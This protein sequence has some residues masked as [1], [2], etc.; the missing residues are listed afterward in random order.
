[1]SIVSRNNISLED[2]MGAQ[3]EIE[4]SVYGLVKDI[5]ELTN[6]S[7]I[8]R[9]FQWVLFEQNDQA[10]GQIRIRM[11]DDHEYIRTIKYKKNTD[12]ADG[13]NELNKP[14]DAEEFAY[15]I[16]IAQSGMYKD[17]YIFP[18]P[19]TE[20]KWE[21]DCFIQKD[22]SYAPW[23]K[24]DLEHKDPSDIP[25]DL[26]F[27]IGVSEV[28]KP[29]VDKERL[30]VIYKEFVTVPAGTQPSAFDVTPLA[31]LKAKLTA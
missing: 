13:R 20:L 18:I 5:N 8:I 1:M 24:F 23:V 14:S 26:K 2:V 30:D 12:S 6:A 3:R 7:D 19:G 22:G 28:L 25:T 17:R 9:Q 29:G 16:E 11:V 15:F 31:E 21:V 10:R 4:Y 27:P